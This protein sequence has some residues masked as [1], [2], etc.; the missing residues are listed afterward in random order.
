MHL[1][2]YSTLVFTLAESMPCGLGHYQNRNYKQEWQLFRIKADF[3]IKHKST[4]GGWRIHWTVQNY[5][6]Y[7]F[8]P[9]GRGEIG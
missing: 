8:T 3:A 5:S 4:G 9:C 7:L 6:I 2:L 1:C